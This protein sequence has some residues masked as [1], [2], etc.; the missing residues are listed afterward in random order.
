MTRTDRTAI[1]SDMLELSTLLNNVDS[2]GFK[3][4]GPEYEKVI[5]EIHAGIA[6]ALTKIEHNRAP[7]KK[8]DSN[9]VKQT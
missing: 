6:I 2:V 7:R 1:L 4:E 3:E 9:G 5:R 8:S